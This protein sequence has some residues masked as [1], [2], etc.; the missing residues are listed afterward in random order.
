MIEAAEQSANLRR[1]ILKERER[2][3]SDLIDE[4]L[5]AQVALNDSP[6]SEQMSVLSNKSIY[7]DTPDNI[8]R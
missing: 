2:I 7:H 1:S 6:I 3:E 8:S 4:R 5:A